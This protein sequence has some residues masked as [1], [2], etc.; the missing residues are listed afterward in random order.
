MELALVL[1]VTSRRRF[2]IIVLGMQEAAFVDET[3]PTTR[4]EV[5]VADDDNDGAASRFCNL[6]SMAVALASLPGGTSSSANSNILIT[7]ILSMAHHPHVT[8][9]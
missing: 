2:D 6:F 9:Y 3:P 7:I 1:V 4:E 5:D 8:Q